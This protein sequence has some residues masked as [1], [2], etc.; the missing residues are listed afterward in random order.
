MREFWP[1]ILTLSVLAAIPATLPEVTM[2]RDSTTEGSALL[3]YPVSTDEALQVNAGSLP[4]MTQDQYNTVS[5]ICSKVLQP[6]FS[7][8]GIIGNVLSLTVFCNPRTKM[9]KSIKVYLTAMCI[10]D[11][12]YM[13]LTLYEAMLDYFEVVYP[14]TV[15]M[16]TAYGKKFMQPLVKGSGGSSAFLVVVI[17]MERFVAIC[18]PLSQANSHFRRYPY[19]PITIDILLNIIFC[20]F[21]MLTYDIVQVYD[22]ALDAMI[23]QAKLSAFAKNDFLKVYGIVAET[24]YRLLPVAL[25]I[26]VNICTVYSLTIARREK[27]SMTIHV[28][29]KSASSF[30]M[31]ATRMLLGIAILFTLCV[32]PSFVIG[33]MRLVHPWWSTT[34]KEK[35]LF[36]SCSA[37]AV[38]FSRLN[39][40]LNFFV[41]AFSSQN[42]RSILL[43][44]IGYSC[45]REERT[46]NSHT[47]LSV[48]P[49][50]TSEL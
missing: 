49:S 1:L 50:I 39:S 48:L 22:P 8:L 2:P 44:M 29:N 15:H 46:N 35:W 30:E 42:Y 19:I 21:I 33:I 5:F 3:L 12:L 47:D 16:L 18:F 27:E 24:I 31:Q 10:M 28:K 43:R 23:W 6:T 45:K 20:T 4:I 26:I 36:R 37:V 9:I 38:F 13:T 11:L 32:L 14:V 7:I 17:S 40:A 34:A 41:Y 25:V